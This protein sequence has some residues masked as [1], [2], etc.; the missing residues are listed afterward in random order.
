MV[1][2]GYPITAL[3]HH[4]KK[5]HRLMGLGRTEKPDD[6]AFTPEPGLNIDTHCLQ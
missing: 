5:R 3:S 2:N 4:F 6:P 1:A